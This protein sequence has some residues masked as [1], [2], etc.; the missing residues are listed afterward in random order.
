MLKKCLKLRFY[1]HPVRVL[2]LFFN[3]PLKFENQ[4]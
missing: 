4:D 2:Q 1:G 3:I